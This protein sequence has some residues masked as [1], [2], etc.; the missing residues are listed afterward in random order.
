MVLR[1]RLHSV[2]TDERSAKL[3]IVG[4]GMKSH[5]G[6]AGKYSR[7]SA[8]EGREHRHDLHQRNQNLP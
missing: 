2:L 6:V 5:T 8:N 7:R 4:V 1:D 3:S